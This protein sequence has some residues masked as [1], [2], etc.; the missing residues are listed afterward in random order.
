MDKH[1]TLIFYADDGAAAKAAA[2]KIRVAGGS[3]QTRQAIAYGGEVEPCD[4]VSILSDVA[5]FDRGRIEAAYGD[6]VQ[7]SAEKARP[8]LTLPPAPAPV[9]PKEK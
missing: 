7:A 8:K 6:K 3:A 9:P 4:A 2:G 5:P 1:L